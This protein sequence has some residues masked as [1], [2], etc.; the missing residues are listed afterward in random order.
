MIE[1]TVNGTTHALDVA[2]DTPLLWAVREHL[3]LTGTRI[4]S[5]LVGE[6]LKA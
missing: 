1:I 3:K 6:Q 4:R 2:P 5:V